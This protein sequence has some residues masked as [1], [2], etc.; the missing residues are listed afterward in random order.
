MY[1]P[2]DFIFTPGPSFFSFAL[3]I[4]AGIWVTKRTRATP[5]PRVWR[6]MVDLL[7]A[8]ATTAECLLCLHLPLKVVEAMM[9]DLQGAVAT[10]AL[11]PQE[12]EEVTSNMEEVLVEEVV[13]EDMAVVAA[14]MVEEVAVVDMEVEMEDTVGVAEEEVATEVVTEVE[15]MVEEVVVVVVDMEVTAEAVVGALVVEEVVVA[16][17]EEA[18]VEVGS[19]V[20]VAADLVVMIGLK[21]CR[22]TTRSS[23]R[24]CPLTSQ[25]M[26]LPSSSARLEQSR[27]TERRENSASSS[28]QIATQAPPRVRAPSPMRTQVQH[29][30]LSNG[31]TAKSSAPE[32]PSKLAWP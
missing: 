6:H 10:P 8:V 9:E 7:A 16:A 31:S 15:A 30:L 17:L 11:H 5:H 3:H 21:K 32:G 20:A 22:A 27:R 2:L 13:E 19:E 24:A 12:V 14:D 23:C 28:I 26:M 29:N 25:K 4:G 18:E 1:I